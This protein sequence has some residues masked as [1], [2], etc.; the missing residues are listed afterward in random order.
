[1][2]E[3]KFTQ[4]YQDLLIS[5]IVAEPTEFDYLL[6]ACK[7]SYFGAT[8]TTKVARALLDYYE[9]YSK[10]PTWPVLRERVMAAERKASERESDILL[11]YLDK[12]ISLDTS[13]W[14]AVRDSVAD[15]LRNQA[16]VVAVVQAADYLREDS[17]PE[18]GLAPLFEA[19]AQVGQN[20]DDL[21]F[22]F[23]ADVDKVVKMVTASTYGIA[24]GFPLLDRIWPKGWGPGWLIVPLAPPKRWKTATCI[25]LATNMVSP[26]VGEDVL[27]YA[28]EISAELA[29]VRAMSNLAGLTSDYMYESPEKFIAGVKAKMADAVCGNLLFKSFSAKSATILDIRNHAKRTIK[30]LGLK[31]KAIFIDYAETVQAS[32]GKNDPEY[33]KSAA[34]Y[35][36]ARALGAE[37]GCCVIMPDR[38]NKETTEAAT[39]SMTS[40]QG[41]FEKAG[42]VD[43][44]FGLCATE[45]E[46]KANVIRWFNFLNRHGPAYQ[47]LRGRV[48]ASTWRMEFNEDVP[49]NPDAGSERPR[50][51]RRPRSS[52]PS[53]LVDP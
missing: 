29:M 25:N 11:D 1:M 6:P 24:T 42:I 39:P 4:E 38:C 8:Q 27:Y 23:H 53:E 15:F 32:T 10:V 47:H 7:A 20:L 50:E 40:F 13:D 46:Y 48:D 44:A 2:A 37:L 26:Q 3:F 36:G 14:E 41:S 5:T 49:Y 12:L 51:R 52:V 35:T 33:R 21:G 43:V 31:P 22:L 34:V 18:G 17:V 9:A 28:C 19:A 16:Y 45:E 30:Q